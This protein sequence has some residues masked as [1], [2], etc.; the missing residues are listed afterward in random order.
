MCINSQLIYSTVA[1]YSVSREQRTDILYGSNRIVLCWT[2]LSRCRGWMEQRCYEETQWSMG[3]ERA[4]ERRSHD[5][6]SLWYSV[7]SSWHHIWQGIGGLQKNPVFDIKI[8]L[9]VLKQGQ[10]TLR[11]K[12]KRGGRESG[13]SNAVSREDFFSI[14]LLSMHNLHRFK[15]TKQKQAWIA[16]NMLMTSLCYSVNYSLQ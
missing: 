14:T 1:E 7:V 5:L 9:K 15:K 11:I 2:E 6:F 8:S 3:H 4:E 10:A 13:K 16:N 12:A